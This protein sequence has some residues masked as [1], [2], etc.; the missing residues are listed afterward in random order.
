[1]SISSSASGRELTDPITIIAVDGPSAS[2]KGTLARGLAEH[3]GFGHIDSGKLYR[4]TALQML[5][6]G[7][8][9]SDAVKATAIARSLEAHD[10]TAPE[11]LEESVGQVASVI[12]TNPDVRAALLERQR[13]LALQPPGTVIDGRDIGTVV[14]P[15][16]RYKFF[17]TASL[18][19]R[20]A[21]RWRELRDQ[22]KQVDLGEVKRDL[23]RRD[24]RDQSRAVAHLVP[25][26]DAIMI[27][28]T[29]LD[30]DGVLATALAV[31]DVTVW[32]ASEHPEPTHNWSSIS[33]QK[34]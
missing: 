14:F 12:A 19:C 26:P 34:R 13:A 3:L 8:D 5:R 11:L 2:G 24:E 20:A 29:T 4:T 28:T 31:I 33:D 22:G 21:R 25:A 16:A 30:F 23:A 15:E 1:M 9:P 32:P 18:D 17:V 10:M 7:G 6:G 27:D